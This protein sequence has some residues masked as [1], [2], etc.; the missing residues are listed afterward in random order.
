M[1]I[2]GQE[3]FGVLNQKIEHDIQIWGHRGI[4][5]QKLESNTLIFAS[6]FGFLTQAT[7]LLF[8]LFWDQKSS[9]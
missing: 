2:L 8:W 6:F 9:Y 5:Y 1:L 4:A 7:M 3:V